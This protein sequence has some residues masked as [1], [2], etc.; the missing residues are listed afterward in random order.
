M[1]P[2]WLSWLFLLLMGYVIFSASQLGSG[3]VTPTASIIPAVTAHDYPTLSE[4][5]DLERW[6]R[7]LNPD[8]AATTNCSLDE[9]PSADSIELRVVEQK[10]GVGDE[11]TDGAKCGDVIGIRLSVW[12]G[13]KPYHEEL[14]LAL[15][16][17]QVAAGLDVGL[18]GLLPDGERL[19]VMPPYALVRTKSATGFAATRAAMPPDRLAVVTVTRQR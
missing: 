15:G 4:T 16:S 7:K 17:R 5:M 8:Y 6:K 14:T 12:S 13:G 2:R 19:L 9:K 1:F 18:L 3:P 10:P 11:A